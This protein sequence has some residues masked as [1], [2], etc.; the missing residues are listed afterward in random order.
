MTK[1]QELPACDRES[2]VHE[3]R[4]LKIS[5]PN[6]GTS[7]SSRIRASTPPNTILRDQKDSRVGRK[8]D[9][10]NSIVN[11]WIENEQ[12]IWAYTSSKKDIWTV[13]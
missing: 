8:T 7:L 3:M 6:T 4:E 9:P 2:T 11:S 5:L 13:N 10:E 12:K 1:R